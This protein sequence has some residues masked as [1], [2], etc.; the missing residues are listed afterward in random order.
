MTE[1]NIVL[2]GMRGSGKSTI[3][4]MLANLLKRQLIDTDHLIEKKENNQIKDIVANMGWAYFREKEIEAVKELEKLEQ[5]IISTGGG[6]V[7][8]EENII[9][10]KKNG[11]LIF[12]NSPVEIL[13]KRVQVKEKRPSLNGQDAV[14]EIPK[15]W[16]ERKNLYLNSAD[17]IYEKQELELDENDA[18]N[19]IEMVN[20]KTP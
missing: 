15:V 2:I 17:L 12:I 3:G 6:V 7:L 9:S 5:K 20:K 18:L 11:L 10:L 14:L 13:Q 1:K 16:E 19:I 8:N 4:K